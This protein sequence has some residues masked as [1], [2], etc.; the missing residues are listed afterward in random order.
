MREEMREKKNRSGNPLGPISHAINAVKHF[1]CSGSAWTIDHL[2]R[3]QV[4][5]LNEVVTADLFPEEYL[6]YDSDITMKALK[7]DGFFSPTAEAIALGE[8][9]REKLFHFVFMTMMLILRGG[10]RTP[11]PRSSPKTRIEL[12]R[13]SKM[14]AKEEIAKLY[15]EA[16]NILLPSLARVSSF[17]SE[18]T[19]SMYRSSFTSIESATI[20]DHDP[21]EMLT[22]SLFYQ[23]L[24][25][26]T[27]E[28]QKYPCGFLGRIKFFCF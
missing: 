20:I 25:I 5:T 12:P 4:V 9:K 22:F 10:D 16:N 6:P 19:Q 2:T 11:T 13:E 8:W 1:N 27:I 26:G 14:L 23:F 18:S 24:Y 17:S 7:N 28:Q 21:R 15:S 3:F